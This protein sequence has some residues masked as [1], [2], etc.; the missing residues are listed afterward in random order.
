MFIAPFHHQ[1]AFH[2]AMS[3]QM[4][5]QSG[6]IHGNMIPMRP[7]GSAAPIR[8]PVTP[9]L[10]PSLVKHSLASIIK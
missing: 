10:K 8:I 3:Q 5:N 9:R 1:A 6:F 4:A 7:E 2:N